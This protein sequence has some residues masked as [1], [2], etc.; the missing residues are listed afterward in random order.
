MVFDNNGADNSQPL[1]GSL[2]DRF[3]RKKGLEDMRLGRLRNASSVILYFNDDVTID[4]FSAHRNDSFLCATL[5]QR[6]ANCVR[7]VN[8]E[9]ENHL[10]HLVDAQGD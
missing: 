4:I 3:R 9:I 10:I 8:Q 1:A 6:V 5:L 2:A 7:G